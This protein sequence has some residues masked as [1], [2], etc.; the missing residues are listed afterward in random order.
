MKRYIQ[1]I[2]K[3]NKAVSEKAAK[4]PEQKQDGQAAPVQTLDNQTVKTAQKQLREKQLEIEKLR[5]AHEEVL[6]KQEE[7]LAFQAQAIREKEN[8][9]IRNELQ[10]VA[11]KLNVRESAF[12]DVLGLVGSKF[13]VQDD[14]IFIES[15]KEEDG[16][17]IVEHVDP[18]T[19]MGSW[20]QGKEHFVQPPQ[21]QPSMV[22]PVASG[23][24][25]IIKQAPQTNKHGHQVFS[26]EDFFGGKK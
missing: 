17:P 8:N 16:K 18:E 21:A 11:K 26:N 2:S 20:L 15:Q 9:V 19:F 5:K 22:S 7:L 3:V 25:P 4:Q 24:K 1:L 14:A 10:K 6:K 13:K 23:P 12:E